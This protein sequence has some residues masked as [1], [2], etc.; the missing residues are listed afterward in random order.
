M[1]CGCGCQGL[2][3]T[4]TPGLLAHVG[5]I[6]AAPGRDGGT[7]P[8]LDTT[9]A[10]LLIVHAAIDARWPPD[11]TEASQSLQVSDSQ[12]HPWIR[13]ASLDGAVTGFRTWYAKN[14]RGTAGHTFTVTGWGPP[15]GI[16]PGIIV[17]A[18]RGSDRVEPLQLTTGNMIDHGTALRPGEVTPLVHGSLVLAWFS[19][20]YPGLPAGIDVSQMTVGGVSD[21]L[22][23]TARPTTHGINVAAATGY[24][25]QP[26][27][28]PINPVFFW[29]SAQEAQAGIAVFKPATASP[30]IR[31]PH[32][33]TARDLITASLRSIR[34]LGVGDALQAEDAND[35]LDRL[36]DWLDA[37]ALERLT[38]YY[39]TR[40]TKLLGNGICSYTIGL[41]G[42]I[43]IVRPT[44]IE[45]ATLIQNVHDP[46]PFEKPIDIWTEQR[47][48]G[49]RQKNL[50][51]TYPTACYY[52]HNWQEGLARIF[53]WP[54]PTDCGLTQLVLYTPVALQEFPTLDTAFSFPPGYRRF[55][56]TNFTAEIASE[57]GKQ[58]T[59]D[60]LMA[61]KQAKAQIKR[62]NVRPS[63]L[64]VDAAL[65]RGYDYFDW[66]TGEPR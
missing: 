24:L 22:L 49:C 53:L 34:V 3:H 17:H 12:S 62:G 19:A 16:V 36:N 23:L 37:L 61:A 55:I 52:D 13:L 26:T 66:R 21:G 45:A 14:A 4:T 41:G 2:I 65:I 43:N 48:Q 1:S 29:P 50:A 54:V 5:T 60:Q 39:V 33:L 57:Y 51:S 30:V 6:T 8:P 58:L 40:S 31:P 42:D 64:R 59:P 38:M 56:R 25:I 46:T 27:A 35:A 9:G 47:W 28:G 10:D 15:N 11:S 7:T 63:E 18:F 20:F 44:H 32:T